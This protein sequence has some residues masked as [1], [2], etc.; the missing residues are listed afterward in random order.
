MPEATI[1]TLT[2][3]CPGAPCP[4]ARPHMLGSRHVLPN[5][6]PLGAV[7]AVHPRKMPR[8][9]AVVAY[10]RRILDGCHEQ[11]SINCDQRTVQ[12]WAGVERVRTY[13][14]TDAVYW[15]HVTGGLLSCHCPAIGV[16]PVICG[17]SQDVVRNYDLWH[18]RPHG[19]PTIRGWA[20][21]CRVRQDRRLRVGAMTTPA[22]GHNRRVPGLA[23]DPA[24]LVLGSAPVA[25]RDPPPSGPPLKGG[26]GVRVAA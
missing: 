16:N 14:L 8:P 9:A 10:F 22:G 13:F 17:S 20:V 25:E 24:W 23:A 12:N 26:G 18:M 5:V 19:R 21:R 7:P 11:I 15:V 4:Q 3:D 6:R 1:I 2:A